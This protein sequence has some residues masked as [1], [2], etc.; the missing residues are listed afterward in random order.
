M[1]IPFGKILLSIGCFVLALAIFASRADETKPP[2]PVVGTW[3]WTFT[4]PDGTIASPRLKLKEDEGKLIGT[5]TFRTGSEVNVTN[6]TFEGSDLKFDVVRERDGQPIIA[7]YSGV[8]SSNKITGKIVSNWSGEEQTYPWEAI[9]LAGIDGTWEW[10]FGGGRGGAGGGGGGGRSGGFR[11]RVKLK[12]EG[13]KLTGKY[14]GF[15]SEIDI[16]HGHFKNGEL[17]FSVEREQENGDLQVTKYYGKL[18]GDQIK[19]KFE[20]EIFG[21][22]R[23]NDWNAV[24]AE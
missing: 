6:L 7:R 2:S 21:Q 11:S 9:R 12:Q 23:T 4:M 20:G 8:L 16:K 17:S 3:R 14:S 10:S 18:N 19:G 15:R 5:S 1:K 13:D 24:R 22:M